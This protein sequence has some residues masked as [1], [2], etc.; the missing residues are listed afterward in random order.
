MTWD[1]KSIREELEKEGLYYDPIRFIQ[2]YK[3]KGELADRDEV[4][5]LLIEATKILERSLNL[6]KN[7]GSKFDIIALNKVGIVYFKMVPLLEDLVMVIEHNWETVKDKEIYKSGFFV[8]P[9]S[10]PPETLTDLDGTVDLLLQA[11]E[12]LADGFDGLKMRVFSSEILVIFDESSMYR[13]MHQLIEDLFAIAK[14]NWKVVNVNS[15]G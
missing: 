11:T 4:L 9:S 7:Q 2:T 10:N 13:S 12:I 3:A 15:Q 5:G 1:I 8:E 14:H 6:I